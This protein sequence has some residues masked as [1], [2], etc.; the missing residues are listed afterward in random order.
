M[1]KVGHGMCSW[2]FS[3]LEGNKYQVAFSLI[4]IS[5]N[6]GEKTSYIPFDQPTV[7]TVAE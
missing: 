3:F 2:A 1:V 4:D 7:P 6:Y 5:G